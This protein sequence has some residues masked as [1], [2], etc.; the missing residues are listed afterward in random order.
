[1]LWPSPE[2]PE[3]TSEPGRAASLPSSAERAAGIRIQAALREVGTPAHEMV[4]VHA[5]TDKLDWDRFKPTAG[6]ESTD[7]AAYVTELTQRVGDLPMSRWSRAVT[8]YTIVP[9]AL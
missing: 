4:V 7:G 2:E 6:A 3:P 5:F 9:K 1:M 8:A